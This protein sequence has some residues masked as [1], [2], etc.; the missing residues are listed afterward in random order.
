MENVLDNAFL[1]VDNL[2]DNIGLVKLFRQFT[3]RNIEM[4]CLWIVSAGP[5]DPLS[6]DAVS[7]SFGINR[8]LGALHWLTNTTSMVPADGTNSEWVR[9]HLGGLHDSYLP[10]HAELDIEAAFDV[11]TEFLTTRTRPTGIEWRPAA[12]TRSFP[13]NPPS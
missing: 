7:L 1:H 8:Q 10:P 4:P 6:P 12:S 9:Y 3:T 2:P 13:A 5:D 11:L